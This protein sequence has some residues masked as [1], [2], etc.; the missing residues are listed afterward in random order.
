MKEKLPADSGQEEQPPVS[1]EGEVENETS[2]PEKPEETGQG[3]SSQ[4][5]GSDKKPAF[6]YDELMKKKGFKSVEALAKSYAELEKK[7]GNY[8]ELEK[9]ALVYDQLAP[10]WQNMI[11]KQDRVVEPQRPQIPD[12]VEQPEE[13]AR[14]VRETVLQDVTALEEGKERLNRAVAEAEAKYPRLKNDPQYRDVV[15]SLMQTSGLDLDSAVAQ[16]D[17]FYRREAER[18]RQEYQKEIEA[19][20]KASLHTGIGGGVVA[21]SKAPMSVREAFEQA[22]KEIIRR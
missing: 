2:E 16:V 19:K 4:S 1:G 10:Y 18:A 17:E 3:T 7:L 20:K 8:S 12:P 5:D 22:E 11:T 14:Y 13:Y 6:I 15:G 9:K 21:S